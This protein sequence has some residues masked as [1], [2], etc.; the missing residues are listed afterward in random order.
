MN[1]EEGTKKKEN[2]IE[3]IRKEEEKCLEKF[4]KKLMLK[5]RQ[6]VSRHFQLT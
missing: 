2:T 6:S 3:D 4:H 5:I 1:N